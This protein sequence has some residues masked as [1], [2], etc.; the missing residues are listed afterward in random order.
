MYKPY[1]ILATFLLLICGLFSQA[2]TLPMQA[3]THFNQFQ[4][5]YGQ[6]KLD[7]ASYYAQQLALES[8]EL[9]NFLVHDN[10]AQNFIPSTHSP[11]DSVFARQLL[12]KLYSGNLALQRSTYP[13]HQW[14]DIQ[15]NLNNSLKLHQL[16]KGFMVAQERTEEEIGNRLDR[17]ALLIYNALKPHPAYA[18]L[19]DTLFEHTR[20]RLEHA[21]NGFYYQ[22]TDDRRQRAGRAYFRYLMAY[23]NFVKANEALSQQNPTL[24]E[25]YLK[26]ASQFSPDDT[27]RMAKSAYFYE[28]A[29]LLDGKEDFHEGYAQF[30]MA[31]GDTTKAVDVLTE[32][33]LADPGNLPLLKN[34]YQKTHFSTIPFQTYW[35]KKLNEKLKPSETFRMTDLSTSVFDYKTLRGKWILID[36]WGTWCQPCVEELPRFQTFYTDLQKN[37]PGN[38]VVFTAASHDTE[39]RVREF[40]KKHGYTF[41]VVMADETF[42]KQFRVGEYPTKVLITP[43][44]NRMKIPPGTNWAERV[45]ILSQN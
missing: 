37:G 6:K 3:A 22:Q 28:A 4:D 40:M 15:S 33:T 26:A 9:L 20:R 39:V 1:P 42:I 23:A 24:A 2:Q 38:I 21:V 13:L 30:L 5:A 8:P 10:F 27:D 17:Y 44:G 36:F 16:L 43:Q 7:S 12:Q 25:S 18:E 14:Q 35:T 29:F 45:T 19:A 34:Y 32:L 11:S 31:K 41:P